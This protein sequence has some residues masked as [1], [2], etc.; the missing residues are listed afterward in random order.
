[1]V[2]AVELA[3]TR[4]RAVPP[5]SKPAPDHGTTAPPQSTVAGGGFDGAVLPPGAWSGARTDASGR[6]VVLSFVG[7]AEFVDGDPCTANYEAS[8]E[9][10][11][12]EVRIELRDARPLAPDGGLA[13][14]LVGYV[15]TVT[16]ELAEPLG[17]RTLFALGQARTVVDGSTLVAPQWVP[18]GWELTIESPGLPGM[19]PYWARTWSPP[20]VA[21]AD[22]GCA[23]NLPG[24]TLFEGQ[25]GLIVGAPA[26]EDLVLEGTHDVNGATATYEVDPTVG[27]AQLSW[28]VGDLGYVLRSSSC[29]G[30]SPVSLDVMLRFARELAP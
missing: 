2:D 18:D 29:P 3:P 12:A 27:F 1:M 16:V 5:D 8:V 22:G 17:T 4:S 15:R 7:A 24:I 13:C 23:P 14:A 28:S 25:T 9:E 30:D 11:G 19:S 6:L 21:S 26:G 20:G 10:S